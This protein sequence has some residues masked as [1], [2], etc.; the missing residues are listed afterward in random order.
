MQKNID[1]EK[2]KK[3]QRDLIKE[4]YDHTLVRAC[5]LSAKKV[6]EKLGYL[7][8]G[9]YVLTPNGLKEHSWSIPYPGF[10]LDLTLLQFSEDY[11]KDIEEIV[12]MEKELA[13]DKYGYVELPSVTNNLRNLIVNSNNKKDFFN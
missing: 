4:Q 9:G 5:S 13:Y 12:F 3:I 1:F 10:I 2:L 6:Y 7:P 8:A 11:K